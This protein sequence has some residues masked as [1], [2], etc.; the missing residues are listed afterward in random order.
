MYPSIRALSPAQACTPD[1]IDIL[2]ALL[3]EHRPE[4][5]T[6]ARLLD[7]H[8]GAPAGRIVH[9]VVADGGVGFADTFR[10]P[11]HPAGDFLA[12]VLVTH[13][14]GR[15]GLGGRLLADIADFARDR[16]GRRLCL[17]VQESSVA[18][19]AFAD[20]HGYRAYQHLFESRLDP[21]RAA[22]AA[23][24]GPPPDGVEVKTLAEWGDTGAHR[25]SIWDL[26]NRAGADEP[27]NDEDPMPYEDFD[28]QTFGPDHRPE[29]VFV[30]LA[31]ER[32]VGFARLDDHPA[33]RSLYHS[34][35]A[36]DRGFRGRGV[37]S[38]LKRAT[39]RYAQSVGASYL[40]THNDS[41]NEAMLA[42][43]RRYGYVASPG[44]LWVARAL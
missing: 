17:A 40:R 23:L 41:R 2:A 32:I 6:P 16:G 36:V 4:P 12:R 25:R 5:V 21:R 33:T 8:R 10:D 15:R 28:R 44:L 19:T 31:G 9:Q 11:H 3:T 35:L 20:K 43:N 29:R 38:A 18:G 24:A 34:G 37:G 22:P 39:I 30:A 7:W 1:N 42:I 26:H 14:A 13:T 27:G